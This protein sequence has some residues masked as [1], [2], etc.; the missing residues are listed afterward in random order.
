MRAGAQEEK[1]MVDD[2]CEA[3]HPPTGERCL[4]GLHVGRHVARG[5][6]DWVGSGEVV[7][8]RGKKKAQS[9]SGDLYLEFRW[10][11]DRTPL[12]YFWSES[13][14]PAH[15]GVRQGNEGAVGS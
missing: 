11:P 14:Q 9:K 5:P 13:G 2:R 6:V 1:A 12:G 3:V 10:G 8:D 7:A 4:R 15:F